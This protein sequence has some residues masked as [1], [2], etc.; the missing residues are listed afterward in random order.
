LELVVA[1]AEPL[2]AAKGTPGRWVAVLVPQTKRVVVVADAAADGV[3]FLPC[4]ERQ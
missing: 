2:E 1:V 3:W 4:F